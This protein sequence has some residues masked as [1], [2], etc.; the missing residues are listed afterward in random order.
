MDRNTV[1]SR[2]LRNNN[3]GNIR[4]SPTRYR[5]E[6]QPSRDRA[7]KQFETMAWG[8]RAMFM[9]LQT[10]RKKYGLNTLRGII[11]RY[12]PPCENDTGAYVASVVRWSG[13]GADAAIPAADKNTMVSIVA[14]MSRVENGIPA[15]LADVEKGWE[16]FMAGA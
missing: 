11:N 16:L 2:G 14:A 12:A 8:Y 5:G 9:L 15:V 3:P 7:F 6:V 4:I 10:Y 13:V 1:S